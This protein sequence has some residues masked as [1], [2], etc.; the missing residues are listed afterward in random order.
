TPGELGMLVMTTCLD[1]PGLF[2]SDALE[3]PAGRDRVYHQLVVFLTRWAHTMKRRLMLRTL[4]WAA[5]AASLGYPLTPDEQARVSSVL[6]NRA[7][8][9]PQTIDHLDAV[10]W[11]CKRQDD[12]I[13]PRGVLDIV[14]A[15]R[16][17]VRSLLPQCP[18][19]LRP[20]L[21]S[22]L[23]NASRLAGWLLFDLND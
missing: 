11:H 13:G 10:L 20:Q 12:V 8:I 3:T 2:D 21:L 7:R 5:T 16:D 1:A 17:L 6:S 14:L 23:G 22:T 9:D 19:T 4:G 18:A 15:Q